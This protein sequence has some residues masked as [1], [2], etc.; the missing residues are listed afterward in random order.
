MKII[1]KKSINNLKVTFSLIIISLFIISSIVGLFLKEEHT[2]L[3]KAKIPPSSTIIKNLLY[4]KGLNEYD[5]G[6][7]YE[8]ITK[9]NHSYHILGTD[10]SGRDVFIILVSSSKYYL[11]SGIISAFLTL[12]M[13][14]LMGAVRGYSENTLIV[15]VSD[16]AYSV[17]ESFPKVLLLFIVGY[18]F[19]YSM[20]GIII[21][22]SIISS[23]KTSNVIQGAIE[24][25]KENQFIEAA[26]E[27]GASDFSIIFKHILWVNY[28]SNIL[29]QFIYA[30]SGFI[31]YECTLA[32]FN[33]SCNT[34]IDT[35]GKMIYDGVGGRDGQYLIH[36]ILWPSI[37]PILAILSI[38]FSF[39]VIA[40]K[41]GKT[42]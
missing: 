36:G 15:K 13:G 2:E 23:M 11:L 6:I 31:I 8:N 40:D 4:L 30:F 3:S 12:I 26:K 37:P 42:N 9:D 20:W 35:W 16:Y 32:F 18:A 19:N 1:L 34:N 28:K 27:I 25:F 22:I 39:N 10:R 5:D 38:I 33:I 41:L 21:S 29:I 14:C 17:L 7:E 24:H